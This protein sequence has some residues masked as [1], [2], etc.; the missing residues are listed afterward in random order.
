MKRFT[1]GNF[2]K[3]L[4]YLVIKKY[5]GLLYETPSA[6]A[7]ILKFARFKKFKIASTH[8]NKKRNN[9]TTKQLI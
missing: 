3:I 1:I 7:S 5:S 2:I 8:S 9:K 4:F 6:F